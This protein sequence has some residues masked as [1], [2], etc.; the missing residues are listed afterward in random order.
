VLE[1]K[2]P[3]TFSFRWTHPAG[4]VVLD[5]NS[6]LMKFDLIIQGENAAE[7]DRDRFL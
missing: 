7:D 4:E 6:L 3:R 1:L 5:R 2:S